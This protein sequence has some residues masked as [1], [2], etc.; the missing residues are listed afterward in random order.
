MLQRVTLCTIILVVVACSTVAPIPIHTPTDYGSGLSAAAFSL[1]GHLA[2]VANFNT[3][4][5]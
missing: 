3:I 2:A 5:I 1:D 4:W